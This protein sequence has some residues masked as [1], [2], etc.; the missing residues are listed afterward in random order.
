MILYSETFDQ[1]I[2]TKMC[3][4]D[5][6]VVF[7]RTFFKLIDWS[8]FA[9]CSSEPSKRGRPAHPETAYIKALLVK[10]IEGKK[11]ITDLRTFLTRHPLL[12]LELGFIPH[13][14]PKETYGFDIEKT[15]PSDSWLRN[16]QRNLDRTLL[17][18]IFYETV[19]ALQKEIPAL[20]ETVA[21]D[22]K[23]IY[24]WVKEN[25]PREHMKDRFCKERQPAGDP[26]CKVGV[27]RSTNQEQPDGSTKVI[28]E[29]LW[30][31]GSGIVSAITAEYGDV[32]LA[33][34]TQTFREGD[35]TYYRSLYQQTINTLNLFP[36]NIT[37]DAAFDAWYIYVLSMEVSPLFLSINMV[38]PL[39]NVILMEFLFA[40]RICEW[41][42]PSNSIIPMDIAPNAI[43]VLSSFLKLQARPAIMSNS[44]K[45]KAV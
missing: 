45:E 7:Y 37:A 4:H 40:L 2:L 14:D 3:H 9:S 39:L 11:H 8:P 15:V 23:H 42:R 36:T 44:R 29:Y 19:R 13:R 32:V 35:V 10:I 1:D 43:N 38:I 6:V 25:N 18:E 24:A 21:F 28:K 27:K 30:G 17:Q 20:G 12:V 5:P 22:V 34:C 33:E 16:K 41:F 26:D 31:Y